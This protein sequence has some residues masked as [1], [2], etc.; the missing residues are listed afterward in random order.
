MQISEETYETIKD[1]SY[2]TVRFSADGNDA[3]GQVK[4]IRI[5]EQ[6][7]LILTFDDSMDRYADHLFQDRFLL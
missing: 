6:P 1:S 2:L 5:D 7:V 4:L 3:T